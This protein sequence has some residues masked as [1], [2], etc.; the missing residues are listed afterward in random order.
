LFTLRAGS[1]VIRSVT[2][3]ADG[4]QLVADQPVSG[5]EPDGPRELVWWDLRSR[6]AARRFPLLRT[7]RSAGPAA[8]QPETYPDHPP[9]DA[10]FCPRTNRVAAAWSWG[11]I[12]D[13]VCVRDLDADAPECTWFPTRNYLFRVAFSPDGTR[14]ACATQQQQCDVYQLLLWP[15]G[16]LPEQGGPI[17]FSRDGAWERARW[18][19]LPDEVEPSQLGET[20]E[21]AFDGR[22]VAC[23]WPPLPGIFVWDTEV[24][25]GSGVERGR[26]LAADFPVARLVL[27]PG[28]RSHLFA[29]GEGLA[30]CDP[31]GAEMR[32][33]DP[34]PDAVTAL[35]ADSS[36]NRLAVGTRD[37]TLELRRGPEWRAEHRWA[38]G[39]ARVTAVAFSPDSMLCA[40]GNEDGWITVWDVAG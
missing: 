16:P 30:V 13:P 25:R 9:I 27:S 39:T 31:G 15:A 21:L 40:T 20:P 7:I 28:G 19:T 4:R 35:G 23:V 36:G 3:T 10:S 2:F 26:R 8:H 11:G 33:L 14:L 32:A 24:E 18:L 17:R 38:S 29:A 6:T 34:P 37:G 22:F 12:E 5:A 1:G